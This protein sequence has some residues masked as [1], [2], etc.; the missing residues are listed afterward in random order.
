MKPAI[1]IIGLVLSISLTACSR[2]EPPPE[3]IRP[4]RVM[5]VGAMEDLR[6][7]QIPGRARSAEEVDLAFDVSG[8]LVERPVSLG[9]LV[10]EGDLIARLDPRDFQAN[11]R[12]A[13][14]EARNAERN[15]ARGKELLSDRFISESEFD[16]L[17]ARV[18]IT[19]AE[20]ALARKALADSEI[21]APFD[22]VIARVFVEN[23]QSVPAKKV[24]ARL[25][26][27]EKVEMVIN[28]SENQIRYLPFI[29]SIEVEYDAFPGLRLP[30]EIT[31]VGTEASLTTRTFP[32]TLSMNQPEDKKILAGMAGVAHI[33]G[34]APGETTTGYVIPISAFKGDPES[35]QSSLWVVGEDN[36]VSSREVTVGR[37]T[38]GGIL[39]TE[40]L[41]AGD[42]VATAGVHVLSEGQEVIVNRTGG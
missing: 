35:N 15:F 24:I 6:N 36:R 39:V 19:Q 34:R 30:A 28:V 26:G 14:A 23:F 10:S 42:L 12:A 29:E 27:Y 21:Y 1:P 20:L 33:T 4:L 16:R 8:T 37:V 5:E 18:D 7:A 41:Q 25:L 17:E 38:D 13:E 3:P 2:P 32:I 11:L 22:G 31:E 9:T 40:G